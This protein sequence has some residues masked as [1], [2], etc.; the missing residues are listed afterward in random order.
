M[1]TAYSYVL[2]LDGV[3]QSGDVHELNSRSRT[4]RSGVALSTTYSK[5]STKEFLRSADGA[6]REHLQQ[7]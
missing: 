1:S 5:L 4:E 2:C 3:I 6:I 7:I